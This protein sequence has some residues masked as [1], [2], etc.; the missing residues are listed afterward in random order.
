MA[1]FRWAVTFGLW[2]WIPRRMLS[3]LTWAG[4]GFLALYGLADMVGA[5][6]GL[7]GV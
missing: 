4:G 5:A 3:A 1:A 2:T 6:L 7:A